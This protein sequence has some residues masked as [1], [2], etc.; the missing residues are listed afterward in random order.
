MGGVPRLRKAVRVVAGA[1]EKFMLRLDCT[2][3]PD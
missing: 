1:R 3:F 2:R